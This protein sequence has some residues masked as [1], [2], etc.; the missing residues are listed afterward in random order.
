[1]QDKD[2]QKILTNIAMVIDGFKS[3]V[4]NQHDFLGF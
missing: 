4:E 2:S 1:M 3:A